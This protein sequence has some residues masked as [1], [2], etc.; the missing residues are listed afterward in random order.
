MSELDS[1]VG[2]QTETAR[3]VELLADGA[4]LVTL[5]GPG[6][7]GKSRLARHIAANQELFDEAVVVE[8]QSID[9]LDLVAGHI[10]HEIGGGQQVTAGPHGWQQLAKL[11]SDQHF[12]LVL[13][14][15]EHLL[16]FNEQDGLD[17]LVGLLLR[18]APRVVCLATSRIALQVRGEHPIPLEPLTAPD[19]VQRPKQAHESEAL[20]LF[21]DRARSADAAIDLREDGNRAAAARLV[22]RLGGIPLLVEQ[23]A[24]RI[25]SVSSVAELESRFTADSYRKLVSQVMQWT[26]GSCTA[27]ERTL[28]ARLT[29]FRGGWS[30]PAAEVVAGTD[31]DD[32]D[33]LLDSLRRQALI[34][35]VPGV[36][37]ARWRMLQPVR[38]WVQDRLDDT[39]RADMRARHQHWCGQIIDDA[40]THGHGPAGS[41]LLRTLRR[42]L[43]NVRA[44]LTRCTTPTDA[45]WGLPAAVTLANA[46]VPFVQ[47]ELSEWGRHHL[48]RLRELYPHQ[49]S[50]RVASLA[51]E[52]WV[53]VCQGD[54]ATAQLLAQAQHAATEQGQPDHWLVLYAQA[55]DATFGAGPPEEAGELWNQTLN[56]L[57]GQELPATHIFL[58]LAGMWRAVRSGGFAEPAEGAEII[59]AFRQECRTHSSDHLLSWG[60]WAWALLCV[61]RGDVESAISTLREAITAQQHHQDFWGLPWS[62]VVSVLVAAERRQW[63]DTARLLGAVE[64][65]MQRTEIS[66][67]RLR[68]LGDAVTSAEQ[69]TRAAMSADDYAREHAGGFT[70]PFEDA[71]TLPLALRWFRDVNAHDE[72]VTPV[73]TERQQQVATLVIQGATNRAIAEQLGVSLA[74]V[75][76]HVHQVLT[77][78]GAVNR[79][80]IHTIAAHLGITAQ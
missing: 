48:A 44:A 40:A 73:L 59:E 52:A 58:G 33:L 35:R 46:R 29:V 79:R 78:T 53:A 47:G 19:P 50:T 45:E 28:L 20:T 38:E 76:S 49:D 22:Y 34:L 30:L 60:D 67:R 7:H 61:R 1:F 21:V 55:V 43:P 37:P 63:R 18:S 14:N 70:L 69:R 42:E 4:R 64:L 36:V 80:D 65:V 11:L 17:E 13:D 8:L 25:G 56:Q 5:T 27:E 72:P 6:G 26:W 2:R 24:A 41:G 12:L 9:D 3:V 57:R 71:C 51:S 66:F 31:L 74:T 39:E 75:D 77:R 62:L 15:C 32:V 10:A 54:P 68:G 16:G 23:V